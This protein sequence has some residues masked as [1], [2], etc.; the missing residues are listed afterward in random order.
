[1]AVQATGRVVRDREGLELIVERRIPAPA[2]EVWEWLTSSARLRTWIG[3]WKGR[4]E[5]GGT[6]EFTMLFEEGASSETLT[7]VECEPG[8]RLAVEWRVGASAWHI[9]VSL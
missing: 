3:S 9:A 7:I 2:S 4:P 8:R 6:I 5:V 1:M